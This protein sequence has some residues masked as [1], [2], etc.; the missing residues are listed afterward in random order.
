[1]KKNNGFTLVEM[2]TVLSIV[3]I[4]TTLVLPGLAQLTRK[5]QLQSAR[6]NLVDAAQMARSTAVNDGTLTVMCGSADGQ[7]CD[8]NKRWEGHVLVFTDKDH[9]HDLNGND[10][11]LFNQALSN[12]FL[13]GTRS[14]LE[15]NGTGGGYMGSWL[16]CARSRPLSETSFKLV[17]SLGGRIRTEATTQTNCG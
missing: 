7:H 6:Q 14:S 15:F 11:L 3:A 17:V 12:G 4:M 5:Q 8:N 10:T 13:L 1:M 2:L 9:N 16:Y